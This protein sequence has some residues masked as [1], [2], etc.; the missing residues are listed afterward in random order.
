LRPEEC[1][2]VSR[3]LFACMVSGVESLV[4]EKLLLC[5]APLLWQVA[6]DDLVPAQPV[7][8]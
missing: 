2:E 1:N 7:V 6:F 3:P 5:Y 4:A 8:W